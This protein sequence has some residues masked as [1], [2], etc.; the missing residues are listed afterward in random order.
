[1]TVRHLLPDGEEDV[2]ISDWPETTY[3]VFNPDHSVGVACGRSG[4]IV[5]LYL[6]ADIRDN[7]ED[8]LAA[9]IL[10]L[11]RLAYQKCRLGLRMEMMANGTLPHIIDQFGH[12]TAAEYREMETAAFGE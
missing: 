11:A 3:E 1:M 10:L 8:W 2:M 6:G 5:G 12:P 9:E 7:A 4:E